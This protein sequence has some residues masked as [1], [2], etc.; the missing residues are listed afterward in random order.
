MEN[1]QLLELFLIGT[2]LSCCFESLT[3]AA[4][5]DQTDIR[6]FVLASCPVTLAM[7]PAR[8]QMHHHLARAL[9]HV[10]HLASFFPF[11]QPNT[12]WESTPSSFSSANPMSTSRRLHTFVPLP[13]S[14]SSASLATHGGIPF[15]LVL[16]PEPHFRAIS[17]PTPTAEMPPPPSM[18][19]RPDGTGTI[20]PGNT[21]HVRSRASSASTSHCTTPHLL[22]I[23]NRLRRRHILTFALPNV[24]ALPQ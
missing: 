6:A 14:S 13:S 12:N 22:S 23:L 19:H 18:I 11:F 24:S 2:Q 4:S 15:Q 8:Q 20:H 16:N 10:S 1:S 17:Y 9:M 3:H 21:F 7:D 5:I